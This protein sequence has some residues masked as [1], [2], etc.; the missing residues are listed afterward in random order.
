MGNGQANH[1]FVLC[2]LCLF[3]P[4]LNHHLFR[5]HRYP[6]YLFELCLRIED[7]FNGVSNVYL[8]FKRQVG[9]V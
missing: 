9:Y 2:H 4:N 6:D 5:Q 1:C 7:S 8:Y 3:G